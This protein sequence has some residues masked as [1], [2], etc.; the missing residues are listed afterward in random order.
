MEKYST[1]PMVEQNK[2]Y[3]A[4]GGQRLVRQLFIEWGPPEY[5]LYTNK[6][7]DVEIDGST[8]RSLQR[9]YIEQDDLGEDSFVSRYLYDW[10]QWERIASDGL[11]STYVE[12]WRHN[13]KQKKLSELLMAL[14]KDALSDS[15]S[16]MSSAKYLI[17]RLS[18]SKSKGRPKNKPAIVPSIVKSVQDDLER[19][20][21]KD[22]AVN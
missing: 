18:D 15:K 16:A 12:K 2:K 8:Y 17:D 13:L 4:N 10:N 3:L 19:V 21:A 14:S 9:L 20:L 11:M 6:A 5:A 22:V 7:Y 1:F